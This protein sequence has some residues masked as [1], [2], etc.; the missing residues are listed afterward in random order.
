MHSPQE[1]QIQ[2]SKY[3]IQFSKRVSSEVMG[4]ISGITMESSEVSIGETS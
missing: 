2:Y 3:S 4:L 1:I